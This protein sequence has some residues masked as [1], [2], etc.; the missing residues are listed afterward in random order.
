MKKILIG[1]LVTIT[2]VLVLSLFEEDKQYRMQDYIVTGPTKERGD[3][4]L[5]ISITEGS[6]GFDKSFAMAQ[7]VGIQF[8]ELPLNWDEIE[9]SPGKYG[10][11]FLNIANSYYPSVNTK[12]LLTINPIDT[13]TLHLPTD[14]IDKDFDDPEVIERYKRLMDYV[15]SQIPDLD[16][17]AVSL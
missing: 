10:N 7:D 3:R 9:T 6:V 11:Q 13:N 12:V 8:I 5:G 2:V 1:I 14:L 15:F 16:L 17:I 4:L